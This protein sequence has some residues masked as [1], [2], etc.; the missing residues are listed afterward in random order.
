[1]PSLRASEKPPPRFVRKLRVEIGETFGVDRDHDDAGEF[2]VL[3]RAPP[4]D[5]EEFPCRTR[6][7]STAPPKVPASRSFCATK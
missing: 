4:A 3:Q 6:G 7:S 2:A 1:M 5:A